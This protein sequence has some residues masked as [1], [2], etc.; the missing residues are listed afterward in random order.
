MEP[1]K[2]FEISTSTEFLYIELNN[3]PIKIYPKIKIQLYPRT[4]SSIFGI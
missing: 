2:V 4:N 1:E 3:K